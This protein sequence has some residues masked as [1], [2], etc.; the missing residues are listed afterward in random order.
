LY[1]INYRLSILA[2]L[3]ERFKELAGKLL[4]VTL[5]KANGRL[6]IILAGNKDRS[7]LSIFVAGICPDSPAYE[8]FLEK[9]L[10]VGDEVLQ[11]NDKILH[12]RSHLN[13]SC[14]IKALSDAVV[15]LVILRRDDAAED[16]AVE[17]SKVQI[18]V[19]DLNRPFPPI[20]AADTP[21]VLP[22]KVCKL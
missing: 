8:A 13:A 22:T 21:E 12:G 20:F 4:F 19:H 18:H 7:K 15:K 10:M 1:S 11:V 14:I 5:R 2:I 16:V 6:G 17:P 9:K 3:E